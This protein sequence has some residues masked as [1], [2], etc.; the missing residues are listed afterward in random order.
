MTLNLV[1]ALIVIRFASFYIK[2]IF[3]S[4]FVYVVCVVVLFLRIFKLWEP[5]V[6]LLN[7]MKL[8]LGKISISVWGLI[9]AS[10][11]FILLY[12]IAGVANRSIDNWLM[13]ST[14]LTSSDRIL[15]LRIVRAMTTDGGDFD[16]PGS[17]W[18]SY[19]SHRRH[20]GSYRSWNRCWT[21]ENWI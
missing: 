16:L 5:T 10:I 15:L 6:H 11:I 7:S 3:W 21:A 20:R 19:D 13:T 9:E 1:G 2:S 12:A 18:R 4:R 17:G 8:E 14:K